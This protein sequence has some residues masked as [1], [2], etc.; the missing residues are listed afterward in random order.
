METLKRI[1]LLKNI[2]IR[3]LQEIERV[4]PRIRS[5]IVGFFLSYIIQ[6][7]LFQRFSK[8]LS[9]RLGI[10]FLSDDVIWTLSLLV[11]FVIITIILPRFQIFTRLYYH[12][13]YFIW[14][15][16]LPHT[17]PPIILESF[18]PQGE[19]K[20]KNIKPAVV[21]KEHLNS[22]QY[23]P[24]WSFNIIVLN[25]K[26][27]IT[28]REKGAY[29]LEV[30]LAGSEYGIYN[31]RGG[32]HFLKTY[33]LS[34]PVKINTYKKASQQIDLYLKGLEKTLP[35]FPEPLRWASGGVLPIARYH[36][37]YWV[38]LFFRDIDPIG[39]N[40]ANGGSESSSEYMDPQKI[41]YREFSEEVI[42]LNKQPS[43]LSNLLSQKVFKLV[44]LDAEHGTLLSP[45]FSKKHETLRKQQ[46]QLRLNVDK[47]NPVD[48][49]TISTKFKVEVK[50]TQT[51]IQNKVSNV[52]FAVNSNEF[53]IEVI[54]PVV[55]EMEDEDYLLDGEIIEQWNT[56]A[57]RPVV[58]ISLDYLHSI[59]SKSK[60]LGEA[61][62][63]SY[64]YDCKVLPGIPASEYKI[65]D[66]D[67]ALRKKHRD[68]LLRT[69]QH[70]GELKLHQHWLDNYEKMFAKI[71][72]HS[73][74]LHPSEHLS[75]LTLCPVTW[76][77]LELAFHYKYLKE[78]LDSPGK[79]TAQ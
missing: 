57:R 60:S 27:H 3:L 63:D 26:P 22:R 8:L 18:C 78:Y 53:G 21:K 52:L 20:K 4:D 59:F 70:P 11:L 73:P 67:I 12:V 23:W 6:A 1:H 14:I 24:S 66:Q 28:C 65:L 16:K 15:H 13:Y 51:Y 10:P 44:D 42:L 55:F 72:Q 69:G 43:P 75:L 45:K 31:T 58:L 50:N 40:I 46:D 36:G 7:L 2:R 30:D 77:V 61:V 48:V 34:S 39:L 37:R 9:D 49:T 79:K 74:D 19:G 38:V 64:E 71:S 33:F 25:R 5:I 17:V 32:K 54:R 68:E 29:T 35:T 62:S 41:I 76:K 56:L 47:L